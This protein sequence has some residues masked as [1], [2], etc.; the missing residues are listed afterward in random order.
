MDE[1]GCV[2]RKILGGR[3]EWRLLGEGSNSREH[4]FEAPLGIRGGAG[5]AG[6]GA[7][8]V[9]VTDGQAEA[10]MRKDEE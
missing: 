6:G 4:D 1:R 10:E 8:K 3:L 5:A 2:T 7:G 9:Q